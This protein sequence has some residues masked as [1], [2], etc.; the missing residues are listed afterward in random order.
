MKTYIIVL[1][2]IIS[3][4]CNGCKG[5]KTSVD[6]YKHATDSIHFYS[7]L[8]ID[9][10]YKMINLY[11]TTQHKFDDIFIQY[12]LDDIEEKDRILYHFLFKEV[13]KGNKDNS[14][15][16]RR[17]IAEDIM[18][19]DGITAT[20]KRIYKDFT[21]EPD[22]NIYVNI[23]DGD[24]I[25]LPYKNLK[26]ISKFQIDDKWIELYANRTLYNRDLSYRDREWG[27]IR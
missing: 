11:D 20:W 23:D 12:N 1:F 15:V 4:I 13:L 18:V 21:Q 16:F 7:D 2:S 14:T 10:T 9:T 3:I 8:G 19:Y 27:F 25:S 26:L 6:S 24:I 5:H 17:Y 22:I